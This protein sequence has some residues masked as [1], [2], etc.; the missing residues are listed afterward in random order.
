[1]GQSLGIVL[2]ILRRASGRSR[3]YSRGLWT[4]PQTRTSQA[5]GTEMRNVP[6]EETVS[7]EDVAVN[8][9][10]Q[11]WRYLSEA[12]RTLYRDVM[13]ETCNLLLSLGRCVTDP[14]ESI[15]SQQGLQPWTVD[16]PPNQDLSDAHTVDD[17]IETNQ[18][19]QG[20]HLWQVLIAN[21]KTSN[22][23]S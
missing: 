12:Q 2:P 11:E 17:L 18:E 22:S 13:L 1:M 20:R 3:D 14:E 16:D 15:R 9:T 21:G 19:N 10:W 7:F 4:I 23:L 8:F 5:A 6:S